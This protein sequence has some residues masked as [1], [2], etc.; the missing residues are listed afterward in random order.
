MKERTKGN[1]NDLAAAA[2]DFFLLKKILAIV[3]TELKKSKI[4]SYRH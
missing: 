3:D 2:S 1:T 4:F